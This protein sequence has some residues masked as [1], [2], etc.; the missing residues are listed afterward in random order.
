VGPGPY[1]FRLL[2]A[3]V[4]VRMVDQWQPEERRAL[5]AELKP[6]TEHDAAPQ[7]VRPDV[8]ADFN[9]DRLSAVPDSSEDFVIASHVLE[10]LAEPIGFIAEIHR[11]LQPGGFTL[12]LLPD[13]HRTEDRFRQPTPVAHLVT[14]YEAGVQEVSDEHLLEFLR[15]RGSRPRGSRDTRQRVLDRYREQ[16][17]HVHCWDAQEFVPVLLWGIENLGQ[18]WEFVDGCLYEPPI[19]YEFGFLLRRSEEDFNPGERRRQFE[20]SWQTW[21]DAQVAARPMVLNDNPSYSL[22]PW[23]YQRARG[24]VR[25]NRLASWTYRRSTEAVSQMR[26]RIHLR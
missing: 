12:V 8:I 19:H 20:D 16:S 3:G 1:P 22:P 2:P 15:D 4:S 14:E 26:R 18:Q 24:L 9:T 25:R 10:H 11:V 23:I 13:R 6:H 21:W 17:I 5:L 7:F